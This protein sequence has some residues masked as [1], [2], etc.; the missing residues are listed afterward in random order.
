MRILSTVLSLSFLVLAGSAD[1]DTFT[2]KDG[3]TL[4]G[5]IISQDAGSYVLDVNVTKTIK[6][7]RQIAKADVVKVIPEKL[8]QKPFETVASQ[9][10]APDFLTKE[11]YLRRISTVEQFLKKFPASD[12]SREAKEILNTLKNESD[13]ITEGG[14]KMNG[15]IISARDF[16]A[17]AY[18]LNARSQEARIRRLIHDGNLLAA[19]REFTTFDQDFRT[20]L[21]YGSLLQL[22]KQVIQT[23]VGEAK[24]S[25]QTLDAR[26][27]ERQLG[28]QRMTAEARPIT[29]AAIREEERELDAAFKAEKDAKIFW[30]TTS[31]FHKASLDEAVRFGESELVR[32][33][34]IKTTLGVDGGKAYREAF[35]AIQ[36]GKDPAAIAAAIAAAKAAAVPPSYMTP[37]EE[38]A[39]EIK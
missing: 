37:L 31:P 17:N 23:H 38:A 10:P 15:E 20:T 27:K 39:K 22:I 3:S 33:N 18:E 11:E 7:T 19:L 35:A 12:H 8:D 36:R 21:S 14:I 5:T 24:Q 2:L 30:V 9:F 28:L 13:A 34:A 25:L 29:E 6:D 32:L 4:E 16:K 1:A 26:L